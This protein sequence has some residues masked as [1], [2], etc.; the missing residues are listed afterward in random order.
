MGHLNQHTLPLVDTLKGLAHQPDT[1]FY[2]PGHKRGR[3][4]TAEFKQWLGQEL[5]QADLP[6]LPELDNLF[7][8]TGAIARAQCLAAALWGA[9]NTWFLINGS[10]AGIIGAILAVCG[11]GDK[12]LL[13]RNV[14]QAAIAGIIHAG[15]RP[16]FLEPEVNPDW[17]LALGITPA[18]LTQALK[19]HPDAKAVFLLHPTYH[20]IVGDLQELIKLSHRAKLPV[21]VDE[22][23]GAHFSFHGQLPSPALGLGADVVIQSTHKMLGALSQA[24]MVHRQGNLVDPQ[25]ISQCLQLIQSTSPNYVLLA[26]LDAARHQMANFGQAIMAEVLEFTLAY[27]E[28]LAQ[29]PG[30]GLLNLPRPVPGAFALDPTRITLD[31]TAWGMSGFELDD[32]LR[33]KSQITAELPTLRQLSFIVS[34]GNQAQDLERLFQ[35]LTHLARHSRTKSPNLTLPPLPS[36]TLAMTPRQATFAPRIM[37]EVN[38][39]MGQI[40]GALLCPYPPGIP[41]L[42]PGE[43][44]TPE[45]IAYLEKVLELGGTVSGLADGALTHLPIVDES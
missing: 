11:D 41:V 37:A 18:T 32:Y 2:A 36:S 12:I 28:K 3:G 8:P 21:I 20:G 45:A 30:L 31:A 5:F 33:E 43:I 17:D 29:I 22:A 7:A 24:A 6:E 44:I 14:H 27:R 26:S 34:L 10:T 13:P 35:A 42:V 39:A 4:I 23:H 16:I 1:P 38:Q 25:R 15:A 19:A 9:E 40:S